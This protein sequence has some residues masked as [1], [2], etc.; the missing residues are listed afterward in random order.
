MLV[1]FLVFVAI[2]VAISIIDLL[3]APYDVQPGF[4]ALLHDVLRI[5]IMLAGGGCIAL[6]A[7]RLRTPGF[8]TAG[9]RLTS[10]ISFFLILA[11]ALLI[12][13]GILGTLDVPLSDLLLGGGILSIVI[14]L[15]VS[16]LFGNIIS[17]ALVLTA[18]PFKV[19]DNVLVNNTIPGQIS[20]ITTLYT[21]VLTTVGGQFVMPNSAITSGGVS[22]AVLPSDMQV[23][24]ERLHFSVGDR[25]YTGYLGGGE[26]VITE[27]TPFFVRVK[28][29]S[30]REAAVF[31]RT[32]ARRRGSPD[33]AGRT[34]RTRAAEPLHKGRLGR[35][36]DDTCAD[37]SGIRY[38]PVQIPPSNPVRLARRLR[39][40]A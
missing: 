35:G 39:G 1:V 22:I 38:I 40:G 37:S 21:V 12:F 7:R 36:E 15:V 17:G 4:L 16:T 23:L 8:T 19:G 33:G 26:G 11:T 13:F 30:N 31:R 25:I 14:G 10:V 32:P 24:K 9:G 34:G 27:I 18:F 5:S 3:F 28:M 29:D 2:A 20:E 6:L